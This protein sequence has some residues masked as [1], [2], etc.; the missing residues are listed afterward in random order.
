[1]LHPTQ[2]HLNSLP[3]KL[4]E[5]MAAG[6][7][8]LTS[9]FEDWKEIIEEN[10]CGYC[11]DPFD[12]KMQMEKVEFILNNPLIAEQ[13][14]RNGRNA[15]KEKFNWSAEAQKLIKVYTNIFKN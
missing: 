15:I 4:F 3:I 5:Y 8:V 1:M 14:G 2:T 6:L 9:D 11:V 13:M 10:K 7:P 12:R